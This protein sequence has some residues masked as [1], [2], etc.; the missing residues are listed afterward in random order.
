MN[1]ETGFIR[2][3]QRSS[4]KLAER[5]IHR[6]LSELQHHEHERCLCNKAS[7][8]HHDRYWAKKQYDALGQVT[9]RASRLQ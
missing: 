7:T 8:V 1:I 4:Q 9:Q 6:S 5:Q 3:A 2:L